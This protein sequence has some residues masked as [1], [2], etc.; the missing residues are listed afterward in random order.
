MINIFTAVCVW[1]VM[2]GLS[3]FGMISYWMES[4]EVE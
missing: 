3:I 4:K 1:I 2:L